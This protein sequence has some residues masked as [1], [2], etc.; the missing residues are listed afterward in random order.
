MSLRLLR[1]LLTAA[2]LTAMAASAAVQQAPQ[3]PVFRTRVDAVTV[4]V[5]ANDSAGR[6]VT[7]LTAGEFAITEH[8]KLQKIESFQRIALDDDRFDPARRT[9]PAITSLDVQEREA[10]RNDVRVMTIFLDEYHTRLIDAMAIRDKLAHFVEQLDPRDMVAI[11]YPLTPVMALTYSRNHEGTAKALR[12][13]KGRQRDYFPIYPQ[14]EIYARLS[15]QEIEQLRNEVVR[16]ALEGLCTY[17]GSL[18][19]GRKTVL[20]VSAGLPIAPLDLEAIFTAAGR[21]NTSFYPL[22]PRG[23]VAPDIDL[24]RGSVNFR[25][26]HDALRSS[27]DF[28]RTL[29]ENTGGRAIV[30]TNDPAPLLRQMITDSSAYYLLGYTSTEAARD[31]KFHPITVNV[32]RRGVELRARK[33]YW[34]YSAEEAARATSPPKPE[35]SKDMAQALASIAAP[36]GGRALH[37][38]AGFDRGGAGGQSSVTIVWEASPRSSSGVPQRAAIVATTAA[39]AVLFRGKSPGEASA[40]MPSGRVTFMAPPGPVQLHVTAEG[41]PGEV[42]DVEDRELMVPDFTHVGPVLS[43]PEVY[44]ARSARE[45]SQLRASTTALPTT[46][47]S[48]SRTEHLLLR[49]HAYGPAGTTP[50]LTVRLR[51]SQGDPMSALAAPERGADGGYDLTLPLGG[52]VPGTYVIEVQAAS[53]DETARVLWA[54]RVTS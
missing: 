21:T 37:T 41:A 15:P 40:A 14:E 1:P 39:G 27:V 38:W 18:R 3:Q 35:I 8:G 12:N 54:F 44:R 43:T 2:L 19:D 26:E 9:D 52:L 36:S 48:F 53:G 17:L 28:L 51:N 32:R 16:G 10:A 7:D 6:P 22:D 33:G 47:V 11:M 4:D 34:A 46:R 42:L 31:G 23:L 5:V 50:A 49:F 24:S 45:L 29:A 25:G 20:M 30:S 13:F